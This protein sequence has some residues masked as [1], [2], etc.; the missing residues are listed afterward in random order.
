VFAV[1]WAVAALFHAWDGSSR[2]GDLVHHRQLAGEVQVLT[3]AAAVWVVA[4]PR[5]L[6]PLTVLAVAQ[7]WLVWEE[8]PIIGN[9][10]VLI[11]F[12]DLA[13]LAAVASCWIGRARPAVASSVAPRFLP[14][15]RLMLL[16]F[17]GFAAFSKLNHG[18]FDPAVSCGRFFFD[19]LTSSLHLGG[20]AGSTGLGRAALLTTAAVELAVPVLLVLRPTRV[21][22]VVL[23]TVFHGVV[24]LDRT[25][26]FADFSAVLVALF[27]VFLPPGFFADVA[28]RAGGRL[29]RAG[30]VAVAG[31]AVVV[32]LLAMLST[33]GIGSPVFRDLRDL[34]WLLWWVAVLAAVVAFAPRH[35]RDLPDA[36]FRLEPR[37]L[38]AIP[39]LVVL[40]G[41][42]PY[43]ELKTAFGWNMYSNLQTVDGASNHFLIRR[44]FPLTH[45]QRGLVTIVSSSA[46]ALQVYADEQWD[47]PLLQLRGYLT[48]HPGVAITYRRDGVE[49]RLARAADDPD[50][51]RPVPLWQHK[52]QVFRAVDQHDP[53]RC[54]PVFL[55]AA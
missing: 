55:P 19:E 47:L 50:L 41:L 20:L 38:L 36:P 12:V 9:H 25:H 51:V 27:L 44:T 26:A 8:L 24:A 21:A 7:L 54:Q 49:H 3:V 34:A 39:L 10:M 5:R 22:G 31:T 37:W 2:L 35:R 23:G 43:V 33:R 16:C 42:T 1:A 18:F 13:L 52:L 53:P 28:D 4:A 29:L 17:Y 14:S 48:R 46:P 11:G 45:E 15:A 30:G 6:L 40:N 32:T